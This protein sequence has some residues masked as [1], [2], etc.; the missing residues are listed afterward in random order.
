MLFDRAFPQYDTFVQI[1]KSL[2]FTLK[3][4][5]DIQSIHHPQDAQTVVGVKGIARDE[6][7]IK[8]IQ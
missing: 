2:T 1:N 5:K 3:L 7:S 8:R 6:K 4:V